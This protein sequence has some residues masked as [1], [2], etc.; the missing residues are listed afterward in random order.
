MEQKNG[1][2]LWMN[3]GIDFTEVNK[4]EWDKARSN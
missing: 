1:L 3:F 4:F 2:G